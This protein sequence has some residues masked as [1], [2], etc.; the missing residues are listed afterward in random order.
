MKVIYKY[1]LTLGVT[2]I[3]IPRDFRILA[4]NEQYGKAF[5]WIEHDEP[6]PDTELHRLCIVARA[7]GQR[8]RADETGTYLDSA[9]NLHGGLVF[10]FYRL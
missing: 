8:W 10:H 9:F 5:A 1:L 6:S 4:I 3:T 7:T 2:T